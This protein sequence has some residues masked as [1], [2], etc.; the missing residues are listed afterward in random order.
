MQPVKAP[1]RAATECLGG[2]EKCWGGV[3][4]VPEDGG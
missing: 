1:D 4:A 3:L 2:V